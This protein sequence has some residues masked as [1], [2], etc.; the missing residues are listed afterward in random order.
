MFTLITHILVLISL[1]Q[2]RIFET[3]FKF[4]LLGKNKGWI[5][6]DKMTIAPG[7]ATAIT[8]LSVTGIPNGRGGD[9]FLQAIPESRWS[10][11]VEKM[12]KNRIKMPLAI[13]ELK[14]DGSITTTQYAFSVNDY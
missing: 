8:E 13:H 3:S 11:E 10:E 4:D 14:L 5:F 2:S 7:S 12:C 1:T 9:V 6:I